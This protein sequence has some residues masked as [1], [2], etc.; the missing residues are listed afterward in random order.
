[1]VFI[2]FNAEVDGSFIPLPAKHVDTGMGFERI[3]G[4][5]ATTKNFTQYTQPTS[6][7]NSDL[8]TDLFQHIS[9]LC[10]QRYGATLPQTKNRHEMT[11]EEQRDC[12]F[13]V[14]ADHIRTVSFAIADGILPGNEGRN[15]VLRRILRRAIL[16]GKRL[17]LKS[18]FFASLVDP[19]VEKM[20]SVFPELR[21][22]RDIIHKVIS[23]EER[24][25]ERTL[26][27][28]LQH[29]EGLFNSH[30]SNKT[31][32]GE[33]AFMLYDTYGFPV[34]LTEIIANERGFSVDKAGFEVAME[35]QRERARQAQQKTVIKL[36][37]HEAA[38]A[39]TRFVGYEADNLDNYKTQLIEIVEAN[40][41]QG[42]CFYA[43]LKESPCYAQMGGQL[44]DTGLIEIDGQPF[45][46]LDT[47][48]DDAG[49]F[50]HQL[51][52]A[53]EATLRAGAEAIVSVERSRRHEI[54]R[55]HS[56][57]HI[58]HWALRKVLG[59]HVGQ[60]G[61][62]VAPNY[63]RFDF[64]HFEALQPEQIAQIE[65]LVQ[66][67]I[68]ENHAVRWFETPFD[69]K[70]EGVI[71]FFG[72]KYGAVVRVVDMDGFSMELC[73]GTHVRS[74]GEIGAFKI[75]SESAISA[76]TRRIEAVAGF[77]AIEYATR[78][79]NELHRMA[80]RLSCTAHELPK[81][82]EHLLEER[83]KM[84]KELRA[85]QQKQAAGLAHELVAQAHTQGS[86]AW[87][88]SLVDVATP[89]DL[90][91]LA[92]HVAKQLDSQAHVVV[93]GSKIGESA[94]VV[95]I[96][97]PEAIAQGVKA[98]ELVKQACAAID[99]K[100][101]GKPDFAMGGG[102]AIAKLDAALKALMPSI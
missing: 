51:E 98:G 67:R 1:M 4:I 36:S 21:A 48:K 64:T 18:G 74:T 17:N 70:P 77:A 72:E 69:K 24:S 11:A 43:V 90:R 27:R 102:K 5:L 12:A 41:P 76:G 80:E 101:G 26:D 96:C 34:D 97:S 81:R 89:E 93:L 83:S 52:R 28:G 54:E 53:P 86:M 99:G 20:G 23:N 40:S 59:T 56:V 13:R 62:F 68:L 14:V 91:G 29:L 15:Y 8:F 71:A 61:S 60:A 3:A 87:V 57:T 58:L 42:P 65:K 19:L 39:A 79:F 30:A 25:F 92:A 2:Q 37:D 9:T 55:H 31:L 88:I 7:Y 38:K 44:G 22:Q 46:I 33:E 63:L 100:G 50:L 94:S 32:T 95:A 85:L 35:A 82:L 84:E 16:F 78:Q 73:G 49:R 10:G 75:T 47:L 66:E 6:N 45:R